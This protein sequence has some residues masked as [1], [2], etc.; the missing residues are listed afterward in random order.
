MFQD[1]KFTTTPRGG[2]FEEGDPLVMQTEVSGAVGS[3]SYKWIKDGK[4]VAGATDSTYEVSSLSLNDDGW[5]RCRVTDAG[6]SEYESDS[7]RVI[8]FEA[9]A[10]STLRPWGIFACVAACLAL[11][12]AAQRRRGY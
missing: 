11:G 2:W 3:V 8:V 5:Y 9:G 1:F 4:E 12:I 7:A 10:L 6:K